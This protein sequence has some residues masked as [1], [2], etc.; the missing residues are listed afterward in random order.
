MHGV[1]FL[2]LRKFI[3]VNY[4]EP[5]WKK[6]VTECRSEPAIKPLAA[7]PDAEFFEMAALLASKTNQNV[8]QVYEKFGEFIAADLFKVYHDYI[9]P[10]WKTF[11][12]LEKA[13]GAIHKMIRIKEKKADPPH[14]IVER[15][16]EDNVGIRYRSHRKLCSLAIGVIRGISNHYNEKIRIREI[17]CMREGSSHCQLLITRVK[18]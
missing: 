4:G 16:N 14:L 8:R 2:E 18:Q 1:F 5:L 17:T 15:V 9:Q 3:H 10:E 13:D 11:D 6:I 7:Y 12:L